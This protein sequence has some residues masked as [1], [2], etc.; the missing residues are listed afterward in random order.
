MDQSFTLGPFALPAVL[1]L[2]LLAYFLAAFVARRVGRR[3][4][5]DAE[6]HLFWMLLAA[7]VAARLAF[8]LQYRDTYLRAPL[9]MLDLRD[10]GWSLAAGL[11][12]AAA[13]GLALLL[14]RRAMRKPLAAAIV[15]GVAVWTAGALL[16]DAAAPDGSRLPALELRSVEGNELALAAF[17]GKPTV[18]NLWATWCPPCLREM[19]VLQQ[20]QAER[21]DVHFVFV[22]QG[23]R[24][25]RVREFLAS[26]QLNLR[27]VLVDEAGELGRLTGHRAL[28]TTLFYDAQGR[29]VD[30]RVGEL[31]HPTLAQRLAALTGARAVPPV[32]A[33]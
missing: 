25:N 7:G 9:S 13:Y 33:P 5:V 12:T 10:G 15:T 28:P 16:L 32:T 8:V 17:A 31:S 24:A 21:T 11:A 30:T 22:N 27:N 6:Q 18:V 19:P 23:E 26:R 29:L 4:G 20:A 14:R 1:P 3:A 2:A